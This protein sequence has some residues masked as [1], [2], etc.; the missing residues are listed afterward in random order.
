MLQ[1]KIEAHRLVLTN[2]P[3]PLPRRNEI[4]I[5]VRSIGINRADL[6]QIQGSYPI[7]EGEENVPGLEVAGIIEAIGDGITEFNEGD[8]VAALLGSGGYSEYVLVNQDLVIKLPG[9]MSFIEGASL[10]EVYATAY[11]N[12]VE[13]GKINAGNKVLISGGASGVGSA[14]IQ[15]SKLYG[16]EVTSL[17]STKEKAEYCLSLGADKALIYSENNFQ[18]NGNYDIILDMYGGDFIGQYFDVALEGAKIITI[19]LLKNKPVDLKLAKLLFKNISLIG[20]TLRNQSIMTKKKL[21]T[22][23]GKEIFPLI[24]SGELKVTIDSIFS[25]EQLEEAI[26]YLEKGEHYGKVIVTLK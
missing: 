9:G 12:L 17:V 22:G 26:L 25:Y 10:L 6:Y 1:Y 3:I 24:E 14:S 23:I 18:V 16:A 2:S 20:S 21:L 15:F 4:L 13:I 11:Y 8:R 7:S 19:A 5:K